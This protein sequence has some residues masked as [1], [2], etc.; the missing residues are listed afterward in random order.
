[1]LELGIWSL[2][3]SPQSSNHSPHK[4]P[5]ARPRNLRRAAI[6]P[7]LPQNQPQFQREVDPFTAPFVQSSALRQ[8]HRHE[9]LVNIF[10]PVMQRQNYIYI[11]RGARVELRRI[12]PQRQP[13]RA[14]G[15]PH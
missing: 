6:I 3:P 9:R 8:I 4:K 1:M 2:K 5:S 12:T 13:R 15:T 7:R 11:Q 10:H 14:P